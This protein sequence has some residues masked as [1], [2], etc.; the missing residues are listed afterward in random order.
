MHDDAPDAEERPT[1]QSL[2]LVVSSLAEYLPEGQLVQ[3][4]ASLAEY[5]PEGQ[6]VQ[7]VDP[8]ESEYLPATH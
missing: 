6:L 5:L 3:E 8:V 7:E 4:V 1:A 2:Q